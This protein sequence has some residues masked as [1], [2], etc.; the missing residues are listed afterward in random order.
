MISKK[1]AIIVDN[2][3]R[4]LEGLVLLSKKLAERGLK[5][6]L[7]PMYTQPYEVPA[8]SPD[9]VILNYARKSNFELIRSYKKAGMLIGILDTEGGVWD[10][11]KQFIDSIDTRT[12]PY[13][14][15]YCLW[16]EAQCEAFKKY[17]DFPRSKLFVTG[18]PRFDFYKDPLLKAM[19]YD[20]S[21]LKPFI[22][23]ASSFA[24][25][26]PK[27][28]S[29]GKEIE[30]MVQCGYSRGVAETRMNDEIRCR[31]LLKDLVKIIAK[32]FS[33]LNFIIR[34]HPFEADTDYKVEFNNLK[35]IHVINNGVIGPWIRDAKIII[36][37]NSSIAIDARLMNKIPYSLDWISADSI[38]LMSGVSYNASAKLKSELELEQLIEG[39]YKT[40]YTSAD[41]LIQKWICS[42]PAGA[43]SL[44]AD[45]IFNILSGQKVTLNKNLCSKMSLYGSASS[46]SIRG[47]AEGLGRFV[48]GPSNFNFLRTW[49]FT[50]NIRKGTKIYKQFKVNQV[51]RI[52]AALG[53]SKDIVARSIE[54]K[55]LLLPRTATQTIV[56]FERSI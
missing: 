31:K 42:P 36:H 22:L 49:V 7:V 28:V 55:D 23:I 20:Y 26:N 52:V 54:N 45:T 27:F 53:N 34:A 51:Q 2:P 17:T 37:F 44:V 47:W 8:I 50:K 56:V 32:K 43:S 48:L 3:R 39:T 11:D 25:A 6:F 29:P 14:D 18:C 40:E 16:G 46:Y 4:D 5:T 30:N 9:M 24:L 33:N 12:F 1:V 13:I 41:N 10:S 15:F 35:N 21:S 38:R 19:E